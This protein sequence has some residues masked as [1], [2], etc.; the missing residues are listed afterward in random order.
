MA[1]N[2][3]KGPQ[4]TI[5]PLGRSQPGVLGMQL[6]NDGSNTVHLS[7]ATYQNNATQ[8][9]KFTVKDIPDVMRCKLKWPISATLMEKWLHGKAYSMSD[10]YKGGQIP[11]NQYPKEYIVTDIC[12]MDWITSFPRGKQALKNLINQIEAKNAIEVLRKKAQKRL[13]REQ[14]FR[15][16]H[17]FGPPCDFIHNCSDP[18]ELHSEWQFQREKVN[19]DL[20]LLRGGPDE[21]YGS[22][23][24]FALYAALLE[25]NF[26]QNPKSQKWNLEVTKVG[27]YMRDTFDFNGLQYLGHW[28]DNGIIIDKSAALLAKM[29]D[30]KKSLAMVAGGVEALVSPLKVSVAVQLEM[31]EGYE[32]H[33]PVENIR[34][35]R[36]LPFNN[37]D[38][39]HYRNRTGKGGDLMVFSDVLPISV[40]FAIPL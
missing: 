11:A 40:K 17:L 37:S 30:H 32:C 23:G 4:G 5:S 16:H 39:C 35:G 2:R 33:K 38:F 1:G 29:A 14:P 20:E 19:L 6:T 25:G 21:L 28:N 31:P 3:K 34:L 24:A 26:I 10:T 12:T 36:L 8:S 15:E 13:E 9:L 27:I 18:V 22:V 7:S